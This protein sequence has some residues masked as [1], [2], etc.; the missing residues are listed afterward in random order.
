VQGIH[1]CFGRLTIAINRLAS[2]VLPNIVETEHGT[3]FRENIAI[4]EHSFFTVG[5]H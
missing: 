4:F 5:M 2:A 3:F 1:C